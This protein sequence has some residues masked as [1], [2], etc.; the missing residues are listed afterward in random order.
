[1]RTV[2]VIVM[3]LAA[4][5]LPGCCK[6]YGPESAL[7]KIQQ[8]AVDCTIDAVKNAALEYAPAVLA[9]LHADL[10]TARKH[11]QLDK[12]LEIGGDAVMCAVGN[13]P[14]VFGG[15]LGGPPEHQARMRRAISDAQGYLAAKRVTTRLA[16]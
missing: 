2:I 4:V 14:G 10:P 7:C 6:K 12:L 16:R 3:L 13:A 5:A 8:L 11:A 1:M 15:R 9:I